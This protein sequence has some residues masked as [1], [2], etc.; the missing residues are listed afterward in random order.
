MRRR[1]PNGRKLST[2]DVVEDGILD[3]LGVEEDVEMPTME[4]IEDMERPLAIENEVIVEGGAL[5]RIPR[6]SRIYMPRI[7]PPPRPPVPDGPLDD[8]AAIKFK[9][10]NPKW[11]S[12]R[13][14]EV[15]ELYKMAKTVGEARRL[16]ASTGH[17][18][19]DLSK[20]H[21]KLEGTTAVVCSGPSYTLTD[22]GKQNPEAALASPLLEAWQH[23]VTRSLP[24]ARSARTSIVTLSLPDTVKKARQVIHQHPGCHLHG[25]LPC[26]PWS[27][28]QRMNMART[29]DAGRERVRQAREQSLDWAAIFR[30]LAKATL[31]RGGSI[32]FEWPRYCEGWK[33]PLIVDM[34][35]GLDLHPVPIDGCAT[36]LTDKHGTPL[37][38]P[39]LIAVSSASL[40]EEL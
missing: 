15:Y 36:G 1:S 17:I 32:S 24:W 11:P 29:D 16:G 9:I 4:E 21:A 3:E 20:G 5:E 25:P 2:E 18:K 8:S 30:R 31:A 19:N 35:R 10:E 13:S 28:W 26:T 39:W 22:F 14:H 33:Q 34:L 27:S 37:Y 40:V 12:S 23:G 6:A 38:K 7:G